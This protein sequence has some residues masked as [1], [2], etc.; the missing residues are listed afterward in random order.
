MT[1]KENQTAI[2]IGSQLTKARM[3]LSLKQS[4]LEKEG[5]ISQ[6]LLSKFEHGLLTVSAS[7]L[8]EL[9]RRYNKPMEYFFT[10]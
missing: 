1:K 2:N 5:L 6:S 10:K 3:E 9:A 8:Y 4:D 7:K